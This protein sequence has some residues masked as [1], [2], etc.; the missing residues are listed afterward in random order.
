MQ[1]ALKSYNVHTVS[2]LCR[3]R[4]SGLFAAQPCIS[5]AVHEYCCF[6]TGLPVALAVVTGSRP[7]VFFLWNSNFFKFCHRPLKFA[8]SV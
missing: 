2:R 6:M 1:P 5:P 8:I 4:L 3:C 7:A